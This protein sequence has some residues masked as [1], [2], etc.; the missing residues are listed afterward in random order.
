[1]AYTFVSMSNELITSDK[2]NVSINRPFNMYKLAWFP[3]KQLLIGLGRQR[4]NG[5]TQGGTP[6]TI[7]KH[8]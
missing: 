7:K 4:R 5:S 1:M 3:I 2:S 8:R 6:S